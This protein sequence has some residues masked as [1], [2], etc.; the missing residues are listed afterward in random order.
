MGLLELNLAGGYEVR[1]AGEPVSFRTRKA[2]A[3]LAYLCLEPGMHSREQ[4]AGLL[5]PESE[6]DAA[7]ANLRTTLMYLRKPLK[8]EWDE[9]AAK[10]H[11]HVERQAI[12]FN[13]DSDYRLDLDHWRTLSQEGDS[14]EMVDLLTSAA[15]SLMSGFS[16]SNAGPFEDW[17]RDQR[18]QWRSDL[19]RWLDRVS[20][21]LLEQKLDR[22]AEQ[23]ARRWI[24]LDP[25]DERA[26]RRLMRIQLAAGDRAGALRTFETLRERLQ[27]EMQIEPM[28]DTQA[29]AERIRQDRGR[30]RPVGTPHPSA[31]QG[32]LARLPFVGREDPHSR[33]V[34]ALHAARQRGAQVAIIEGV[35]GIGKTRLAREFLEWARSESATILTGG[36]REAGA[37]AA[38]Q[39]IVEALR[40]AVADLVDG[41]NALGDVW[42]EEL[43]RIFPEIL[44]QRPELEVSGSDPAR[45]MRLYESV[46]KV[47]AR[48]SRDHPL[49]LFVDDLHWVDSTSLDVFAY[50]A[51]RALEDRQS[52]MLLGCVRTEQLAAV[53]VDSRA[54][55]WIRS[56]DR[57]VPVERIVLKQLTGANTRAL[58]ERIM[59]SGHDL[60]PAE[61]EF[62]EWIHEES[63][64]HPFFLA[65]TLKAM[66][67]KGLLQ[68]DPDQGSIT[69]AS[70]LRQ[71]DV[72][73]KLNSEGLLPHGVKE[74]V[75]D[76]LEGL[77]A[78]AM[79]LLSAGAILGHEFQFDHVTQISGLEGRDALH[80]LDKI[81]RRGLWIEENEQ[82]LLYSFSHDKIRD[83]VYSEAGS[84]RRRLYHRRALRH[85]SERAAAE[86]ELARHAEG[87]GLGEEAFDLRL[88][89]G[90][91]AMS[92]PAVQAAR[93]QFELA[94]RLVMEQPGV[95]ESLDPDQLKDLFHELGRALELMNEWD[96]AREVYSEYLE[97]ARSEGHA[98]DEALALIRLAGIGLL[99]A[100][101]L[102]RSEELLRK[103]VRVA[104]ASDLLL[105]EAEAQ[106]NLSR[107]HFLTSKRTR[108][109][110]EAQRALD[111]AEKLDDHELLARSLNVLS[112]AMQYERPADEAVEI[113]E[114][115]RDLY[116]GIG[117]RPM[118]IDCAVRIGSLRQFAGQ[119]EQAIAFF[120]RAIEESEE[121]EN[122]W[123]TINALN[124]AACA[125]ID[126]GELGRAMAA[127]EKSVELAR[128]R[129]KIPLVVNC[130]D[131]LGFTYRIV[132]R[133]HEAVAAHEEALN[134][135]QERTP[136]Q[137]AFG[138][139]CQLCADYI[140]LGDWDAAS[141]QLE[142][143]HK[144]VSYSWI[145]RI[146]VEPYLVQLLLKSGEA[147]AAERVSARL[148]EAAEGNPRL[149][150]PL[151][152][153]EARVAAAAGHW[154]EVVRSL[155]E[156]LISAV[157]LDLVWP[158]FVVIRELV[159]ALSALGEQEAAE[160]REL[161]ARQLLDKLETTLPAGPERETFKAAMDSHLF[162]LLE[163][164]EQG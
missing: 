65:E 56:V 71:G 144:S 128:S 58:L 64:G 57:D 121:I 63:R 158:R 67:D 53:D 149:R 89:A 105:A 137:F 153:C 156:G 131:S 92:I 21:N 119:I 15:G 111:L 125:Y 109:I 32:P 146:D 25:F 112:Y 38:Y 17:L 138:I 152:R 19:V 70:E 95:R 123:G 2:L 61:E 16:V 97:W 73:R 127:A 31:E 86:A 87:A 62:I 162:E 54:A 52:F 3:M 141:R 23:V 142:R 139:A 45:A 26:N 66:L 29:L 120:E 7:R 118:E 49:I 81:L 143:A 60:R 133:H 135:A 98:D 145:H 130:L 103:A 24:E 101:G 14:E 5:W 107:K 18:A 94:R 83:V 41:K 129:P 84:E 91:A 69:L 9:S 161:E 74:I 164:E 47:V 27:E 28:P 82:E 140:A 90:R 160:A 55:A 4:L 1:H 150:V 11:L 122:D 102:D 154:K 13:F 163:H 115:A 22:E 59:G 43:A 33:L 159:S 110:E 148:A 117:D 44:E 39:P 75:R 85:L 114:R 134:V 116:A 20:E 99:S 50:L 48:L 35:A 34:R 106:I 108:A 151:S 36:G 51:R 8:H 147:E 93:S 136:E 157:Q 72:A 100:V 76:R 132:G 30:P 10:P 6:P 113:A 126:R 37:P 42:L 79:D 77:P 46:A 104:R 155:E 88:Q 80:T 96:Q 12:G 40:P 124:H 78:N 68:S